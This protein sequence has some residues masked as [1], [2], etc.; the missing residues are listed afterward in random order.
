MSRAGARVEGGGEP[1]VDPVGDPGPLPV[2]ARHR[3]PF[4]ADVAGEQGAVVG[5]AAGQADRRIPGEGADFDDVA[6]PDELGE[7][8]EEQSLFGGDLHADVV[9][10][11][12]FGFRGQVGQHFVDGG[13]VRDQVGVQ[14]RTEVF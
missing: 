11:E 2:A 7:Q 3:G 9:G 1:Q 14:F 4:F 8:G 10:E 6:C 5:E 12:P 13:A